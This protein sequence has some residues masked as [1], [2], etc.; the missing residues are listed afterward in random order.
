M[1][2]DNSVQYV[3]NKWFWW[4][5]EN[6]FMSSWS[7]FAYSQNINIYESPK[8]IE[9]SKAFT[10]QTLWTAATGFITK[11]LRLPNDIQSNAYFTST[12]QIYIDSWSG[13]ALVY[14]LTDADKFILNAI[15]FTTFLLIFTSTDIHKITFTWNDFKTYASTSEAILSFTGD[16][17]GFSANESK[18]LCVYNFKDSLLYFSA[19]NKLFSVGNTL[20]AVSTSETFR[21]WSKIVW[22][23]FLNSN[24]KIYINYL[25]VNSS[26]YFWNETSSDSINYKNRVFKAVTTDWQLDYVVCADGLYIFNGYTWEKLFNY[27]FNDF[28]KSGLNYFVPQ[29]LMSIDPYF[30]YVAYNKIIFKFGKKFTNLPN[31]FSISSVETNNITAI[32]DEIT[33]VWDLYYADDTNIVYKQSS[34]TYK[35]TWYLEGIVF[36]GDIMEKL[37]QID[38]IFNAFEIPA[39][40]SIDVY[41]SV[42]WWAYPALPNYT[43]TAWTLNYKEFFANQLP[44]LSNHRIKP[45]IVLKGN[46]TSTPKLYEWYML[47]T[48]IKN[49]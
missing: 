34:S 47:E 29:N 23:T 13:P 37:K 42:N 11:V 27:N 20:T 48:Y 46:W 18:D 31:W 12:W 41:L 49:I 45:K 40:C 14:T 33:V 30:R 7:D 1:A 24:L 38:R 6:E 17:T 10:V 43:L 16:Y 35:T 44:N 9:L 36:Y 32:S 26:L 22:I 2:K 19:G 5:S 25:N 28:W 4:Q 21:K 15:C 8:Y 3:M 39:G